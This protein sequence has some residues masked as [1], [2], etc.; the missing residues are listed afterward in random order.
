M[1]S[2]SMTP[3]TVDCPT[4]DRQADDCRANLAKLIINNLKLE[5]LELLLSEFDY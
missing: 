5:K 2:S 1:I 3:S 4:V